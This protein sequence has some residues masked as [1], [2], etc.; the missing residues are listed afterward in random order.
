MN[1]TKREKTLKQ[2]TIQKA[3]DNAR[4]LLKGKS[5]CLNATRKYKEG[6]LLTTEQLNNLVDQIVSDS[7][8][9]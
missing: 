6:E 4:L 1:Y 7:L 9:Y 5:V 3:I 8:Y 2:H